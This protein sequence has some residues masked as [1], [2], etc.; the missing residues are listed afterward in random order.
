MYGLARIGDRVIGKCRKHD[1]AIF[2]GKIISASPNTNTN[3]R[4]Q[5]RIGDVVLSDCGHTGTIITG[6]STST[7]NDRQNA[8]VGSKFE[9]DYYGEIVTGSVDTF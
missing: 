2:S 6:K 1:N 5:A 7:S 8:I 3:N 9:G 4:S